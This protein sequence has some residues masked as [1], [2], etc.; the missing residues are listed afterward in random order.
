MA[1]GGGSCDSGFQCYFSSTDELAKVAEL[2]EGDEITIAD[3][4][5]G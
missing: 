3:T 4:C 5:N 2:N 1:E